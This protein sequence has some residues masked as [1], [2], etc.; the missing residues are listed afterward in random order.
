MTVPLVVRFL[1][2]SCM[3]NVLLLSASVDGLQLIINACNTY[4]DE[5]NLTRVNLFA[6]N[7]ETNGH[8]CKKL[9]FAIGWQRKVASWCCVLVWS[10]SVDCITSSRESLCSL[11]Q[12]IL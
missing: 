10:K 3:L 8:D 11:Q 9:L 4:G 7:L 12:H 5:Y 1:V 6:L 2:V